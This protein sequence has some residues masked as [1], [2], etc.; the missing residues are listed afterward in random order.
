MGYV[1]YVER[2]EQVFGRPYG[3]LLVDAHAYPGSAGAESAYLSF[4]R[5]KIREG[6]VPRTDLT[7]PYPADQPGQ[8]L[9][10]RLLHRAYRAMV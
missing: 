4:L 3:R 9:E 8:K 2:G 1:A 5:D 7:R 6:F 10:L